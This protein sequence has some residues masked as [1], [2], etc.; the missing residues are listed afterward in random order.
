MHSIMVDIEHRIMKWLGRVFQM[1]QNRILKVAELDT[2][3]G[4]EARKAKNN[5]NEDCRS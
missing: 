3:W 5:V 2:T 1:D 4:N